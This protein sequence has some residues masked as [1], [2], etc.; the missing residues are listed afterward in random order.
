MAGIEA[1]I[2]IRG[3]NYVGLPLILRNTRIAVET[4]AVRLQHDLCPTDFYEDA[5]LEGRATRREVLRA[6]GR[7]TP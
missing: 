4:T 3:S 5:D 2:G 6:V 7:G 1:I